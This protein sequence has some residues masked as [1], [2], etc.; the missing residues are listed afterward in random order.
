MNSD[1]TATLSP[2]ACGMPGAKRGHLE[3]PG[4]SRDAKMTVTL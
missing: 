4:A 2:L 3:E 1:V